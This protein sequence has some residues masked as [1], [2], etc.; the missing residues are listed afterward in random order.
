MESSTII[1]AVCVLVGLPQGIEAYQRL[2]RKYLLQ[3]GEVTMP[4]K[5]RLI[6][7]LL[8]IG[9]LL[10]VAFGGWM[11]GAK[12]LRPQIQTVEKIVYVDRIVPC[13]PTRTGPA[14]ARG[15]QSPANSGSGN[16]TTYQ[17]PSK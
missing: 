10:S 2:A 4:E 5:P 6:P 9:A 3:R 7:I 16:P 15:N 13:Q 12:P 17:S 8:I 11:I 1:G 14:S